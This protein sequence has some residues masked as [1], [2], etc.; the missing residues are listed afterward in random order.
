MIRNDLDKLS[1]DEFLNIIKPHY[2]AI[3]NYIQSILYDYVAFYI[4]KGYEYSSLWETSLKNHVNSAIEN[5]SAIKFEENF[6]YDKLKNILKQ[7][8]NLTIKKDK[9]M[10][11]D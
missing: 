6:D 11:I 2:N 3:D 9:P 7:K 5:F 4:A 8:Y 1:E 10:Q